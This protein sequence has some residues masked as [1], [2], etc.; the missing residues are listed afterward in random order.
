MGVQR[1]KLRIPG[2][3]DL[4]GK[5]V[6]YCAV[7]DGSFFKGKDVALIGE[8]EE[9]LAEGLY[10][11]GLVNKLYL[12]SG[13]ETP[14]FHQQNLENLLSKGNVEHLAKHKVTKIAGES[15]VEK[16]EIR[17]ADGKTEEL[18]V[19]GVFVA[20]EKAPVGAILAST[21]IETDSSGCIEVDNKMRTNLPGVFAAGD[22]TCGR[23]FQI[24]VSVG[25][26][27]TAALGMIRRRSEAKRK[28][29]S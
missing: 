6:A 3:T 8:D 4:L 14:K 1:K 29:K 7:C 19:Q 22:I 18:D 5:G 20:G 21:G 24:A 27:V 11:S 9:T 2:A 13:I 10:L 16:I 15:I 28:L 17:S 25:Q 12:I 23:K 26:G